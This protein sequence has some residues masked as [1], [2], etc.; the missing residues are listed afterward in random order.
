MNLLRVALF[1]FI[2]AGS[3]CLTARPSGSE[4]PDGEPDRTEKLPPPPFPAAAGGG[5]TAKPRSAAYADGYR[6][7]VVHQLDRPAPPPA[8]PFHYRLANYWGIGD[9]STEE[10]GEG[11]RRGSAA[12]RQSGLRGPSSPPGSTVAQSRPVPAPTE[13]AFRPVGRPPALTFSPAPTVGTGGE[14]VPA[15]LVAKPAPL[16]LPPVPAV[17]PVEVRAVASKAPLRPPLVAMERTPPAVPVERTPP[18]VS[19]GASEFG[20]W[21]PAPLRGPTVVRDS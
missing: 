6:A 5:E 18:V 14:S 3:G 19:A 13:T 11:F 15:T 10:W 17:V 20:P 2:A 4:F 1:A 8:P 16:P 12:V 21:R 9:P 7:G